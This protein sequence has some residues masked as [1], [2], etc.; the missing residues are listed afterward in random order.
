[1]NESFPQLENFSENKDQNEEINYEDPSIDDLIKFLDAITPYE[2]ENGDIKEIPN[3]VEDGK[4]NKEL[5][6]GIMRYKA[7]Q[8][9]LVGKENV[10][11][12][13]DFLKKLNLQLKNQTLEETIAYLETQ[14]PY[15]D[16]V[17]EVSEKAFQDLDT[18]KDEAGKIDWF[19]DLEK[20][21]DVLSKAN[22]ANLFRLKVESFFT[23][24]I[25]KTYDALWN[26]YLIG[27]KD[28]YKLPE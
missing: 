4:F 11:E 24:L 5:F 12:V 18:I 28:I 19:K 8:Y 15:L 27:N 3:F 6:A 20:N 25:N 14:I 16:T 1:M 13:M 10:G 23:K 9:V 21:S 22:Q 26:E 7:P 2:D 17:K